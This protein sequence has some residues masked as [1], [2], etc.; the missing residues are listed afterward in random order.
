MGHR[1]RKV[2]T[3]GRKR[4]QRPSRQTQ[5]WDSY[6]AGLSS[7]PRAPSRRLSPPRAPSGD[8]QCLCWLWGPGVSGACDWGPILFLATGTEWDPSPTGQPQGELSDK[9]SVSL[10]GPR[11]V[12]QQGVHVSFVWGLGW[13]C[14][15]QLVPHLGGRGRGWGWGVGGTGKRNRVLGPDI[16]P[17]LSGLASDPVMPSDGKEIFGIEELFW[18]V[19]ESGWNENGS[20][21]KTEARI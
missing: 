9:S 10:A 6:P 14:W 13:P 15:A 8:C 19:L 5:F 2:Q 16:Y 3:R 1:K 18:F 4:E 7:L 11:G 21:I 20:G 17:R 12:Q